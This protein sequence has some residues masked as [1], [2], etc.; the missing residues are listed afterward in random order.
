[1]RTTLK[2]RFGETTADG[3]GD[4]RGLL[5]PEALSTMRRYRQPERRRTA[6]GLLGRIFL[7]ATAAILMVLAALG[8]GMY[9]FFHQNL[10]LAQELTPDERAAEDLLEAPL[11]DKPTIALV[12]GY[13][14]RWNER[15]LPSRSDT[16]ILLRADPQ[17]DAISMLSF[18][19]DLRAEIQCPGVLPF[20]GKINGAYAECG[21][22][23][24]LSTVRHLTGLPINYLVTVDFRGFKQV[25]NR[26]DGVWIDVDRR[27]YNR[28]V[29]TLETN[30]ANI[31]LRP[32]YQRLNGQ[33]ALDYV[34][35]RH[36][37]NDLFRN[38]RQQ[39]FVGAIKD[40]VQSSVS[41][42]DLPKL[43][44][45]ISNNVRVGRGGGR[46]INPRE[47]LGYAS[48]AASL[49][50]GHFFQTKIENLEETG[51]ATGYYLVA[52][53]T[54]LQNAL[55]NFVSPDVDAPEKAASVVLGQRIGPK[56]L[57]PRDI[58]VT[59]LNGNG[60][61]GSAATARGEL[62][63]RGFK[64]L[65]PPNNLQ[66]NAPRD[67]Y[68]RTTIYWDPAQKR[69]R[70]AAQTLANVFGTAVTVRGIPAGKPPGDLR[71]LSNGAMA[72]A[73]V[74]RTFHGRLAPAP[75]D[76]TPK[77]EP[78]VIRKDPAETRA[79]VRTAQRRTDFPLMV[80]SVLE[81]YSEPDSTVPMRAYTL[82]DHDAVRLVFRMPNQF[83]H[84]GIQ[85]T[86][87]DDAP[88][89]ARPSVPRT[90]KGRRYDLFFSGP[91]LHMVVLRTDGG[92]YWVVNTLSNA[93][94]NETMLAIAKGLRP[95]K[96]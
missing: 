53:P 26:L 87:W 15:G 2:R 46:D 38:A 18:P 12:V 85:Q 50:A 40:Q 57:R 68:W 63:E 22:R 93:L 36:T 70:A 43:V 13:D 41:L 32:G 34:R 64:T 29:G 31:N 55:A 59:V 19:R 54:E 16:L 24:A 30:Y 96:R 33:Q 74:G 3:N 65:L 77:K 17:T 82:A 56:R 58:T 27:Y 42:T 67:S 69:A 83:D 95:V 91:R 76:R 47:V 14:R 71:T 72:V 25:V 28:N 20:F 4:G 35:Y 23:G 51:D 5:L 92:T 75:E 66:A 73:V 84:W 90:I 11:P 7:G 44:N 62:E 49:P 79:L 1:V 89:L 86:D 80:P 37:D 78:P 21:A 60:V 45:A 94:S 88:I 9:L 6:L 10:Q 81:R 8:G 61:Q 39:A 52:D 48:F